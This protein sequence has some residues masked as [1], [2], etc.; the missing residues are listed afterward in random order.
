MKL[1]VPT[2]LAA[3]V[4]ACAFATS[5]ARADDPVKIEVDTQKPLHAVSP[6][7]YGIF[8]EEIN[9]AGDGGIYA[10]MVRD[11]S[12]D[13]SS[14]GF[15]HEPLQWKFSDGDG[16]ATAHVETNHALNDTNIN[17]VKIE[18][19]RAGDVKLVNDGFHGIP[20]ESGKE[21]A[22]SVYAR[23]EENF[24][25]P[26]T[27]TLESKDGDK[28]SEPLT[29]TTPKDWTK[30]TGKITATKTDHDG[31]LVFRT[32]G[33]GT[34]CLDMASL[35]PAK[36]WKDRANGLRPDLMEMIAAM[37][38]AFVRFPGG[39]YV[40]GDKMANAFRW[41]KTIGD[42]ATRP[43]H[44]N[45]WGYRSNDGLGMFEY[46]QMCRD[47]DAAPMFV[48]SVGMSHSTTIPM[49]KMDE[50]V[51]DAVDA[52]E[53]ANGSADTTWGKLRAEHGSAEPFNLN[54]IEIGNENGG[55][56]YA[57]RYPLV[58]NALKKIAPDIHLIANDWGGTPKDA[59]TDIV[60]EHY[61]NTPRFFFENAGKYDN[62]PRER[63]KVYV[64]E[65]ACTIG[66]GRG[67][68]IAAV[69]EAAFMTGLERNS[70]VVTMASYAPL[71][72]NPPY[73]RWNPNAIV[74]N[75]HEAYGTPSYY[76]QAM[77]GQTRADQVLPVKIDEPPTA[78]S[79]ASGKI[80]IGTWSTSAEF[81]DI[82]VTQGGK[83]VLNMADTRDLA[84]W[85]NVSGEWSVVD[86]AL[87]QSNTELNDAR[88]TIGDAKWSDYTLELKARKLDG[89]E[90]FFVH[91]NLQGD[92]DE[93]RFNFG[94]WGNREHGV[95]A[96]GVSGGHVPGT[97]ETNKWYDVKIELKGNSIKGYLDGKLVKEYKRTDPKSIYATVGTRGEKEIILKL[98]N[99]SAT[100][101]TLD[102]NLAGAGD[103][104]P[105]A[106]ATILTSG[107]PNDENS[108]KEPKKIVP[109][110][111][112]INGIKPQFTYSADPY[113][114]TI[115][116]LKKR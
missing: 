106:A 46:L 44:W 86:G 30:F 61:Y 85:K 74:F 19:T 40:E 43:G 5:N 6:T 41:K 1:N 21:Y 48:T 88:L 95:Q 55:P 26:L 89:N 78:A 98:V 69:S 83:V 15:K 94:G 3:L 53:Y 108:F 114:V 65:Y 50:I 116:T 93:S 52:I 18:V 84:K 13:D 80:G 54:I 51:A 67:N 12:F 49:D 63:Y 36:T 59:P 10:E 29:I 90:G 33:T 111:K 62:Y 97:I 47:L 64:G 79:P 110:E 81:K 39:C 17:Y 72:N 56:K 103:L 28:L 57:E 87:R 68:L 35:F 70:D 27:V 24:T 96:S 58:Y 34:F 38:P 105:T 25:G 77:F 73:E 32:A 60:D 4:A 20:V 8:F 42:I 99:G 23:A 92:R 11:R 102:I 101:K 107:N 66:C 76:V 71:L 113:S 16:E 22:F 14:Q 100:K 31:R 45:L 91:F 115:L 104:E 109:V 7:L 75:N 2:A 9:R 37:K 82:K 112:S